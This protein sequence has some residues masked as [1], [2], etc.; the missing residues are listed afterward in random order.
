MTLKLLLLWW[1]ALTSLTSCLLITP[2]HAVAATQ[3]QQLEQLR[4]AAKQ[5][6]NSPLAHIQLA[7][8]L[9]ELNHQFPDGGSRVPEAEQEYRLVGD[10]CCA[11]T[12]LLLLSSGTG[13]LHH[14]NTV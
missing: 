12:S 3:Q 5:Q 11:L 7:L 8:A 14:M 6:P 13:P 1:L 2:T 10:V 9:H 4:H